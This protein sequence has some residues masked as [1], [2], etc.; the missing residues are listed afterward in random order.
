MKCELNTTKI[1]LVNLA[2]FIVGILVGLFLWSKIQLPYENH[3][4]VVGE[5]T[6]KRFNPVNNI[7][8]F[9]VFIF[10]PSIFLVVTSV[11][12]SF[13]SGKKYGLF[14]SSQYFSKNI[15]LYNKGKSG[16]KALVLIIILAVM[17]SFLVKTF[18]SSNDSVDT[19]HEGESLGPA[20]SL[21]KGKISYKDVIYAHG[22]YQDPLR[23]T[24]AFKF[25]GK[26]IGSVRTLE[27]IVK[28]TTILLISLFIY[29]TFGKNYTYSIIV[30]LLLIA[31][32]IPPKF[33]L[34]QLN[35]ILPRDITTYAYLCTLPAIH[36]IILYTGSSKKK[37]F[38]TI[39]LFSFIPIASFAYSIDRGFFLTA[40]FL[41][42]SP[43]IYLT[44]FKSKYSKEYFTASIVGISTAIFLLCHLL[45]WQFKHFLQ[46][47][48]IVIPKYKELFDGHVYNIFSPKNF[49]ICVLISLNLYW[50]VY[51]FLKYKFLNKGKQL[52]G[53]II[54]FV[55][56]HLVELALL[57]LS[58]FF[59]RSALGRSD[60]THTAMS[61]G[62]TYLLSIIIIFKY[63]IPIWTK[64]QRLNKLFMYI[65]ICCAIFFT[66]ASSYLTIK[67]DLITQNFPIKISDND[68]ISDNYKRTIKFLKNNLD[69]DEYFLTMTN[70]AI[71][72]YFVG[73]M[74][75][76]RFP[77]VI[78]ASTD[79]YQYELVEDMKNE[80]IK[81]II[82]K[83]DNWANRIDGIEN[84]KRL[85]IV[86]EYIHEQ[87][88]FFNKIDDN[89]IW[90]SKSQYDKY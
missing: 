46:F 7:L 35:I 67:K 1:Y 85:P 50:I 40:S 63:Y 43:L 13:F 34:L 76:T 20:I 81:F 54:Q 37:I 25:F 27:S 62:P 12:I 77:V 88:V 42:I 11:I 38:F 65:A 66:A 57:T 28:L 16:E 29:Q 90:I 80:N 44:F 73:K 41:I 36:Y 32:S 17:A 68:L 58:I 69:E 60:W 26:S 70:E 72:Y 3:W 21:E 2:I 83:S 75:P 45:N 10:A 49:N 15:N 71:W 78:F 86:Y 5:L 18:V 61:I 4:N 55:K 48:F 87:Y 59:F 53:I 89:E 64:E 14:G 31:M 23:S 19:F 82:Y 24:I 84:E 8:R 56:I 6:Y 79:F 9:V 30:F 74:C 47:V 22:I 33:G 51:R 52:S 39:F